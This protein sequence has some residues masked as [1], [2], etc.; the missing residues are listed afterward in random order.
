[1]IEVKEKRPLSVLFLS[2]GNSVRSIMAEAIL[3]R[4][5]IGRFQAFSA[6]SH[7]NDRVHP[8]A[9][10]V[11]SKLN[12]DVSQLHPKS[13][14][15]FAGPNAPPLDFVF[16]VCDSAVEMSCHVWPG[17]PVTGHW[18]IPD[19]TAQRGNEAE[20]NLAF[21]DAFRMLSR[22]VVIFTSLPVQSLDQLSLRKQLD[23]IGGRKDD[24]K[25]TNAA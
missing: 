9:L 3:N 17:H 25:R 15:E 7:P 8:R 2:G 1:M 14:L 6:G 24:F 23:L 10:D 22:R 20:V 19:P 4:E 16:T 5:G 13:C 11:L 12:F 18:E 21:A